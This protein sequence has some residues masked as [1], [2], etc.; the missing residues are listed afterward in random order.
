MTH[1]VDRRPAPPVGEQST[2]ELVQ[3][4]SEQ[5]S[6]LVRDELALAKEELTERGKHAGLG[7]GL[8]GGGGLVALFGMGALV[9]AVILALAIVLPGWAAAL[10]VAALLFGVAGV[11]ALVG[12]SQVRQ[13][14]PPQPSEAVSNVRAD[15][16]TV[17]AAV[18][19]GRR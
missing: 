5:F 12:R 6:K 4:A 17:R 10:I 13:A 3:R 15:V 14:S 11:L 18:R 2:A 1:V 7:V 9:A 16:D 8:F 19:D